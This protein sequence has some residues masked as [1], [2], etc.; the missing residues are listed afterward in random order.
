MVLLTMKHFLCYGKTWSLSMG[1]KNSWTEQYHKS[2]GV[3]G[4]LHLWFYMGLASGAANS[5]VDLILHPGNQ[6]CLS[7]LFPQKPTNLPP[8][9]LSLSRFFFLFLCAVVFCLHVCLHE[10]TRSLG[11]EITDSCELPG[12][13]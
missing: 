6:V 9:P 12:L 7:A 5:P 3:L 2:L 8:L 10:G 13:C 1:I 4:R 11:P